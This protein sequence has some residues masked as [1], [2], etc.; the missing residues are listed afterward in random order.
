MIDAEKIREDFPI[1]KRKINDKRFIYLN[2]AATTQKPKQVIEAIS[3]FYSNHHGS[4]HRG[5]NQLSFEASSAYDAARKKIAGFIGAQENELVFTRN[6]TESLNLLAYSLCKGKLKEGDEVLVSQMEHHSNM[7]PWQQLGKKFGYKLKFIPVNKDGT[8]NT[9]N[10]N[11]LITKK[12]RVVSVTQCS[13]VL[14]T[15]NDVKEIVKAAHDNESIAVVDGAQSVPHKKIDVKELGCDFLAFSGHKM[16][17]PT[18]IGALYGKKESLEELEPFLYGGDM[19]AEVGFEKTV[20]AEIPSRFE[21]G[22]PNSAGAIGLGAA[23]SY[24]ERIG[25]ENVFSHELALSKHA[26][27]KLGELDSVTMYGPKPEKKAAVFS[28]NVKNIHPHDV[29]SVL[30]QFGIAIRTG[31]HCAQPLMRTLG[32]TGSARMSAYIYNSK[33]DIDDAVEALKKTSQM[34]G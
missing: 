9:E 5:T 31:H 30:D 20:F 28:F 14:G 32:I 34:L 6:T 18:G 23:V 27:E 4:V 1:F 12:T 33:E 29:G 15:F 10:L 8:L 16:L 2:N 17:G 21:A 13:N 24:I 3:D 11:E 19:I 22:T 26:F 7:V 25:M